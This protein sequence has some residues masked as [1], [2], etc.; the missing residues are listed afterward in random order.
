VGWQRRASKRTSIQKES[1]SHYGQSAIHM[2]ERQNFLLKMFHHRPVQTKPYRSLNGDKIKGIVQ[3]I[4]PGVQ[5]RLEQ[6]LLLIFILHFKD[7][8]H[9]MSIKLFAGASAKLL[10]FI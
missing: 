7:K 4:L 5:T 1:I 3:Q 9:E 6:S 2:F 10:D 8:H